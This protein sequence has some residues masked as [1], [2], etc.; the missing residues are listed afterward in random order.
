MR[1]GPLTPNLQPPRKV[2]FQRSS[3]TFVA[4]LFKIPDRMARIGFEKIDGKEGSGSGDGHLWQAL[5]RRHGHRFGKFLLHLKAGTVVLR[6]EPLTQKLQEHHKSGFLFNPATFSCS[7]TSVSDSGIRCSGPRT[8]R[9]AR[10]VDHVA[11]WARLRVARER[12]S[13][14]GEHLISRRGSPWMTRT[15]VNRGGR[16]TRGPA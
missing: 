13:V 16:L 11:P 12:P 1:A 2:A 3:A 14:E 7:A 6:A 5:S 15:A 8:W 9:G 4:G 10:S